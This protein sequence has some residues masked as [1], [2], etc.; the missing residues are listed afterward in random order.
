MRRKSKTL[1]YLRE[2]VIAP[3][4]GVGTW[5]HVYLVCT[6]GRGTHPGWGKRTVGGEWGYCCGGVLLL[7]WVG[8]Y[9]YRRAC[10][11]C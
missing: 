11:C 2:R 7:G 5:E 10:N 3:G 9:C 1:L 4:V 8:Y 6:G